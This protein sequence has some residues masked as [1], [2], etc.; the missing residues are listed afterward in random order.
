MKIVLGKLIE[1]NKVSIRR[2]CFGV[3]EI[4]NKFYDMLR[5]LLYEA[6]VHPS[7]FKKQASVIQKI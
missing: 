2:F 6:E 1:R 3:K 5:K 4:S 7:G